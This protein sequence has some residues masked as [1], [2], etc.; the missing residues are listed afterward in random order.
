MA[1]PGLVIILSR[2]YGFIGKTTNH[3][4][5]YLPFLLRTAFSTVDLA[6]LQQQQQQYFWVNLAILCVG[7]KRLASQNGKY[8]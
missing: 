4:F 7:N 1:Q 5:A 3:P 8:N 6:T 2:F